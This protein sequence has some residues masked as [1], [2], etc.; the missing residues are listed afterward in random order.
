LFQDATEIAGGFT[1]PVVIS[2][3]RRSGKVTAQIAAFVI[4]N[5]DGWAITAA[6]IF[7]RHHEAERDQKAAS[8]WQAELDAINADNSVSTAR[9]QTLLKKL[10]RPDPEWITRYSYSWGFTP[11]TMRVIKI[12]PLADLALVKLDDFPVD[13]VR[14]FPTFGNP[15]RYVKPGASLCRLGYPFNVLGSSWDA[16]TGAFALSQDN[17][18]LALFPL[19]GMHTRTVVYAEPGPGGRSA[20]FLETS[21]PGLLGQSGGPI[22]DVEG[23]VWAIQSQTRHVEL[24]FNPTVTV[25]GRSTVE[26]Q[27]LNLGLGA[28]VTEIV[29]FATDQGVAI[30]LQA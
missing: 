21:T 4:L 6:H 28:D 29:R 7:T 5:R 25:N 23:T 18:P 9:K 26:H 2:V 1:F 10:R 22:Y 27:I 11:A 8:A 12:D 14:N 24:G 20:R 30:N 16:A 13:Q 17:L 19:E 3:L 15:A